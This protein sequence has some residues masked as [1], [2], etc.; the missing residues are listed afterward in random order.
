MTDSVQMPLRRKG[1]S[2]ERCPASRLCP[3]T[4]CP[5]LPA[6]SSHPLSW[7]SFLN[8]GPPYGG[9]VDDGRSNSRVRWLIAYPSGARIPL[10][11]AEVGQR[12][13]VLKL[14]MLR[15]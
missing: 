14:G 6:V 8:H 4:P 11:V 5:S 9:E 7:I 12:Q 2:E 3:H 1:R 10:R 15:G 13:R